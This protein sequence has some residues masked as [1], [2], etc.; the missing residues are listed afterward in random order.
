MSNSLIRTAYAG[1]LVIGMV[2]L[3]ANPGYSQRPS[4]PGNSPSGGAK[5]MSNSAGTT[6]RDNGVGRAQDRTPTANNPNGVH[7]TD[8]A[9]GYDRAQDR[10]SPQGV[11][12]S[13]AVGAPNRATGLDR[14][15]DRMSQPGLDNSRANDP[16]SNAARGRIEADGYKNVQGLKK[17]SDGQWHGQALR[18][19][20]AVP[21]TVDARGNV[22]TN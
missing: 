3:A 11:A 10:M 2:T 19:T 21:V 6:D 17:G 9:T 5:T 8:R 1:A 7:A 13:N 4:A 14:A 15:Q 12:N 20:T 22:R 16:R 18:G